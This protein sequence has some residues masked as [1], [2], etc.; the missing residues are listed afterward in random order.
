MATAVPF[1][2]VG[3]FDHLVKQG[4]VAD[5]NAVEIADGNH[6][7][8]KRFVYGFDILYDLHDLSISMNNEFA[9]SAEADCGYRIKNLAEPR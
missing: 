9:T 1:M 2:V 7:V 8:F 5:V 6:G 4:L 3:Q